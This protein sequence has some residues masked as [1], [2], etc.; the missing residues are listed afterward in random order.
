VRESCRAAPVLKAHWIWSNCWL[1]TASFVV[2]RNKLQLV[3]LQLLNT[4]DTSQLLYN[5]STV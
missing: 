2:K 4:Q 1:F 5:H 3:A